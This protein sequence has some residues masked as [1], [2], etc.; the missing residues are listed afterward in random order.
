[1]SCNDGVVRVDDRE[2]RAKANALMLFRVAFFND[3]PANEETEK[4]TCSRNDSISINLVAIRL[5][6][7]SLVCVCLNV[8]FDDGQSKALFK[9]GWK[10]ANSCV[11]S[12]ANR[13]QTAKTRKFV[14]FYKRQKRRKI[15]VSAMKA[16]TTNKQTKKKDFTN[17]RKRY[18]HKHMRVKSTLTTNLFSKGRT[19]S[20]VSKLIVWQ[21]FQLLKFSCCL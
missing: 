12:S 6:P 1:M 19:S 2:K 16:L 15:G 21:F 11:T 13:M 3:A 9:F 5:A 4:F 10:W 7:F 14:S 18:V 8:C 20:M 17:T